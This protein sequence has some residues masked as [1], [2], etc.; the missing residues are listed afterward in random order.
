VNKF[1]ALNTLL[2]HKCIN[3]DLHKFSMLGYY[4]QKYEPAD[5]C[6]ED[7]L[8]IFDT[9][10]WNIF[11]SFVIHIR[12]ITEFNTG[13][14]VDSLEIVCG[15]SGCVPISSILHIRCVHLWYTHNLFWWIACFF[16]ILWV[17]LASGCFLMS[18]FH[19]SWATQ[20]LEEGGEECE[21]YVHEYCAFICTSQNLH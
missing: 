7:F 5:L 1:L 17:M 13:I 20:V 6:F 16:F 3:N 19:S 2:N 15:D 21:E 4:L 18:S 8:Y 14:V 10:S 12:C 11:H 9:K